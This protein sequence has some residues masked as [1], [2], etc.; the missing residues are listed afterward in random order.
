MLIKLLKFSRFSTSKSQILSNFQLLN[1]PPNL[2]LEKLSV[3]SE[4]GA[5]L[6]YLLE[7]DISLAQNHKSLFLGSIITE[8]IAVALIMGGWSIIGAILAV[9]GFLKAKT[10]YHNQKTYG[11]IVHRIVENPNT[12]GVLSFYL[13]QNLEKEVRIKAETVTI[14]R[15]TEAFES[16][17]GRI[18]PNGTHERDRNK[19]E[20]GINRIQVDIGGVD[21]EILERTGGIRLI[22]SEK[23]CKSEDWDRFMEILMKNEGKNEENQEKSE[24]NP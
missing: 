5:R 12:P 17:L 7:N 13:M 23:T 9:N 21:G 8:S 19:R 15:A 6:L 18:I 4:K 20:F 10:F 14:E 16:A 24:K 1:R 2:S 11:R 22:W 3:Y